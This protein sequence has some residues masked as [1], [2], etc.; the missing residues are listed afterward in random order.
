MQHDNIQNSTAYLRS[1]SYSKN[2]QTRK[3]KIIG[4]IVLVLIVLFVLFIY[5]ADK[6][7][8]NYYMKN[9]FVSEATILQCS[10]GDSGS[11]YGIQ[12]R[13]NN[14]AQNVFIDEENTWISVSKEFYSAHSVGQHIGVLVC[15]YDVYKERL[16][17]IFGKQGQDFE[18][19]MWSIDTA[20]G[21]LE[22]HRQNIRIASFQTKQ[23]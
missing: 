2:K 13:L 18:K 21:S 7:P 10:T 1:M 23:H 12:V 19:D 5:L 15:N 16:F 14:P 3:K 9:M 4:I 17:G 20:Y 22:L 8:R 11:D 6:T